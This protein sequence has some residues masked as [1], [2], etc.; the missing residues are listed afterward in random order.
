MTGVR[1]A[2]RKRSR[3][4]AFVSESAQCTMIS[5]ADH[6]PDPGRHCIALAGMRASAALSSAGPRPYRSINAWRSAGVMGMSAN[7]ARP[8]AAGHELRGDARGHPD[9]QSRIE[10]QCAP[11]RI[12]ADGDAEAAERS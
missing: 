1:S 12:A 2:R 9:A 11:Q 8:P 3:A 10:E 4:Y 7:L 6:L 5:C